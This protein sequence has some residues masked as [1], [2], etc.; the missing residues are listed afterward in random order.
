MSES[1][2]TLTSSAEFDST[3]YIDAIGEAGGSDALAGQ[4]V[5]LA[6]DGSAG[7]ATAVVAGGMQG[8]AAPARTDFEQVI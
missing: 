7:D 4:F 8:E 6:R 1:A 5:L 3:A 2:K